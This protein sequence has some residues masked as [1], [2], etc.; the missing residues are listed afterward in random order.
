[1]LICVYANKRVYMH[2]CYNMIKHIKTG[3]DK[4]RERERFLIQFKL[5]YYLNHQTRNKKPKMTSQINALSLLRKSFT[6]MNTFFA[7]F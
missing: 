6:R 1:M 4:E 5:I 7:L 3:P 2:I